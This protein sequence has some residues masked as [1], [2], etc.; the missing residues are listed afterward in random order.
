MIFIFSFN[1]LSLFYIIVNNFQY[2]AS[3][4]NFGIKI[5]IMAIMGNGGE[6]V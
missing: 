4:F 2:V 1:I 3:N 5:Y 6:N